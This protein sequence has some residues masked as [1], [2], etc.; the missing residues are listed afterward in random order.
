[1]SLVTLEN[2]NLSIQITTLGAELKSIFD[3]KT[4]L[5]YLWQANPKVWNR[6][7]PI[8]FPIVGKLKDNTLHVDG[9]QFKIRQH[10]FARDKEFILKY[11]DPTKAVFELYHDEETI[12]MYPY[13]FKL[14]VTYE[15]LEY[16]IHCRFNVINKDD[17]IMY[18]S[19]GGHPGFALHGTMNDYILSIPQ[20]DKT[21]KGLRI[22]E[23]LIGETYPLCF[24]NDQLELKPQLFENDAIVIEND[25]LDCIYLM[26]EK[27]KCGVSL[28]MSDNTYLGIW[29]PKNCDNM[30]CIEPW[31]GVADTLEGHADIS[32]KLGIEKLEPSQSYE[33][34]YIIGI[35][36]PKVL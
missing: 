3:K 12:R 31:R 26:N 9:K 28:T 14:E 24:E 20:C 22:K 25:Q 33:F 8:L 2:N 35:K 17:K 29:S 7:A 1:M 21:Y 30:L 4:M 18:F 36:I 27:T 11:V 15:L 19:I 23:G 34:S 10:G 5:E 6:T 13:A 16:D 32:Q